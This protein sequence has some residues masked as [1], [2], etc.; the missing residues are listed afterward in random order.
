MEL[1]HRYCIIINIII[2]TQY[3]L[4]QQPLILSRDVFQGEY[5]CDCKI[6]LVE[7]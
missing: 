4:I 2:T 1:R 6:S 7:S 5:E 3:I